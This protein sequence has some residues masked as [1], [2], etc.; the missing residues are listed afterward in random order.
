[1]IVEGSQRAAETVRASGHG[2]PLLRALE[3]IVPTSYSVNVPNAGA[4]ADAPVS[5]HGDTPFVRALGEI[6]SGNRILQARVNTDLHLVTVTALP[7]PVASS[8]LAVPAAAVIDTP[9]PAAQT[10]A[11]QPPAQTPPMI[12]QR[13]TQIPPQP[14]PQPQPQVQMPS[15][16][17]SPSQQQPQVQV[18]SQPQPQVQLPP[19]N[20]PA[21]SA[22]ESV[23]P[24]SRTD[25]PL[26]QGTPLTLS[27][28]APAQDPAPALA[29]AAPADPAA[30]RT[31]ELRL[32]DGSVRTALAR[33]AQ[34]A[35]WQFIWAVP[36]DFTIDAS[37][38]IHGS[39]EDALHSV[40][41]ALSHSQVPIQ[42]VL[43][44]GNHVLRVTAKGAG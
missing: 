7:E 41:D 43:Y 35:G 13:Q 15:P 1:M 20:P 23:L 39:F 28:P 29:A 4:W 19:Q 27:A 31:W 3:Q 25:S 37:A 36:T 11:Q 10:G 21:A 16:S 14:Q 17:P 40:V 18:Q 24:A 6:L 12:A 32:A 33:W 42:A 34:D 44:K 2:V 30:A 26:P 5:W 9:P 8:P 22:G 38:T